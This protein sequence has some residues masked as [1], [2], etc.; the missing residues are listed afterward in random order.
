MNGAFEFLKWRSVQLA[1]ALLVAQGAF[2]YLRI[3]TIEAVPTVR[4]LAEIP[5]D[6]GEFRF[7]QDGVVDEETQ[8]LLRADDLLNRFYSRPDAAATFNVFMAYFKTQ[9]R[10]VRPHSP[11]NCMPGAGWTWVEKGFHP[12][13]V[14]GFG[15][16]IVVNR[17]VI[18]KGNTK[19]L[20][21]YW[22]Q[23]PGRVVASEYDAVY[24]SI[25]DSVRSNRSDMAIV[26][27]TMPIER[28]VADTEAAAVKFVQQTFPYLVRYFP[29]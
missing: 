8:G 23:S 13:K 29:V 15:E 11:M 12:I 20:V 24:Y 5:K 2:Y 6:V 28:S 4:P 10:G 7:S 3:R 18:V 22:Y 19:Q 25:L 14:E 26:K 16:P 27:I 9:R 21:L 1:T 17:H